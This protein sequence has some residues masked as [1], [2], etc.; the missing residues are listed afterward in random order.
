MQPADTE[1]AAKRPADAELT[2]A[3]RQAAKQVAQV[4]IENMLALHRA[5]ASTRERA[6]LM[7][8]RQW[9]MARVAQLNRRLGLNERCDHCKA[10]AHCKKCPHR[11]KT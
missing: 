2:E 4:D 6:A 7:D 5:E 1:R 8:E 11:L 10:C 3:E 9:L